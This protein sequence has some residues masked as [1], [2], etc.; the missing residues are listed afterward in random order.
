MRLGAIA[1]LCG[2]L[3]LASLP[4]LPDT[5]LVGFLPALVFIALFSSRA[6]RVATWLGAGFLWAL[7]RAEVAVSNILPAGLEGQD[8]AMEG[9]IASIPIPAGRKTGFLLDIHKVESPVDAP[10]RTEW[11]PGQRIRLNWYGKPPR[12]LPGERWRLTARLKRPRGFRNPGGFDYEKWLFQKGIRATGYVRAGAENR[13]LAEGERISLTRARHRL[14]GMIEERVDSPYAGIVQALAIG[15]RDGVTQRQWNTLRTTG[16]AHLM[17]I[18]GLHIGLVA[19]LFFFGARWIWAWLPGMALALPAQ[20]VAALAAMVGA[21]GYAAL[22]GFSL[23]TQRALV[24]VCVV[25]AGILLRRHVSAG[26]SLA[27]ALL[28]V[29]LL[30]PFAVLGIGFWLSF[31][32][33]A[34]ILLGMT[35]HLSARNPWWRWGRVQVLVAIGLL[36]LTL[37]FFQQHPLVGPVANLVAIPWVGF[38]VVP[39][40]LAGIC[41]VG[42]FP[43]VGG[44]LLGAGSSAIAVFWPL[45]DWF[46]SLDLVYRGILAPPLWTVLAGGVGVVLL[47]LPRGIPGRWL[48]IIWLLPLFLVPAPRPSMGEAWFD[49]LDVGQGLA[50]VARTRTHALVYDTGPAYSVRF[51]AGRDIVIPF[52]RSQGVR[53][54]D[55]VIASHGDKDHTG[56]LKGLLAEFPVDTLMMNGSFMEGA[57]GPPAITPCRAGMAWRWDEVDFQ[58]LPPPRS[59]G[60]SGNEGSCVLKVSNADGAILLTGDIERGAERRLVREYA[61]ELRADVLVAPH[62]GSNSS[63]SEAFIRAVKP[64]YVLFSVGYRNRFGLPADAVIARYRRNGARLLSSTRHGAIGFRFAPGKGVSAPIAY[65]ETARR[66]WH[67]NDYSWSS[68]KSRS[69]TKSKNASR[70]TPRTENITPRPGS[71]TTHPPATR[72]LPR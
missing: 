13:R 43:E 18:S 55:R 15:I 12:L 70:I 9:I 4:N 71:N 52:L 17:A 51:E 47:L 11:G 19:T 14:A 26:S 6:I 69:Y 25:M 72:R 30:E 42:V 66:F 65:R 28:M 16:T 61:D 7:F 44:A 20:W 37:S 60:A 38:V 1:F 34:V 36:P 24:M 56:G 54:V 8:L 21:L 10:N 64:R 57:I 2:I 40:V 46:A 32:A 3:A 48:G 59:G 31:G 58:I 27:L 5:F 33:V 35:G 39:L 63:S 68:D 62:H 45:L 49:L 67:D 41:L 23:P 50:A 53:S 22:A 29:L